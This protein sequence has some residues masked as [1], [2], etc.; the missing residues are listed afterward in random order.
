ME[1]ACHD[2][3]PLNSE[4]ASPP[5][6]FTVY[7]SCAEMARPPT[8]ASTPTIIAIV[9]ILLSFIASLLY[10]SLVYV[11]ISGWMTRIRVTELLPQ[12]MSAFRQ[13]DRHLGLEA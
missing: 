11:L 9:S 8:T 5:G 6:T 13:E 12:L 4:N 10:Q 7:F 2:S 3:Y 1:M